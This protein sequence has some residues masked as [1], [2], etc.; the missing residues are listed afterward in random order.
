MR[1]RSVRATPVNIPLRAPYRFAYGS[2]AALT[3]TVV[4]VETEDGAVGLGEAADGDRSA[5]IERLGARLTGLDARDLNACEAACVPAMSYA[6]WDNLTALRRAFGAIEIALWDVR[7]RVEDRPLHALLGGAVRDRIALTEYFSFRHPGPD[8]PG[9]STPAEVAGYCA[10]MAE[11]FGSTAFEGKLGT[12]D[13]ATEVRMLREVRAAVGEQAMLRVDANGSFTVG[14]ALELW[15]IIEPIGIRSFEDP[16]DTFEELARVQP[17]MACT[18]STHRP[19]LPRALQ[20]GAPDVFVCNLVEL[21]GIRR[22]VEFVRACELAGIGFWFHS[23]ETGIGS[24]A[25]LQ[26][27]AAVEPIRDPSQSLLRWMADDVIAEGPLVPRDGGL[28]VPDGPGLGVT[29]DRKA[30]ERCHRR[31]LADGPF[32]AG[33]TDGHYGGGFR[34]V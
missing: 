25:Y 14:S 11:E 27:S 20:L 13:P 5:D 15:R 10:R 7:G 30:L 23:G 17:H 9:E 16:V 1:I 24:A 8:E 31:Y 26:V 22:T 28:A 4:E 19:D 34:R 21:G 33:G 29:L 2:T 12:L 18:L 3:K 32:P 6:P